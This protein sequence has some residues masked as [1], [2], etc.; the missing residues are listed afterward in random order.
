MRETEV[1]ELLQ[2][3]HGSYIERNDRVY[4][5]MQASGECW[6]IRSYGMSM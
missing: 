2:K 4:R 1:L 5:I 3:N 6:L